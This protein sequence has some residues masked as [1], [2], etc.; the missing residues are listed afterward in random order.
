MES[1]IDSGAEVVCRM[2]QMQAEG[3]EQTWRFTTSSP[4]SSKI[5][6]GPGA[7]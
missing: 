2:S 1:M 5:I 3:A 6:T 7:C 4:A